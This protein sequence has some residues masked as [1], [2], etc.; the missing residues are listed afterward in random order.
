MYCLY[1][2]LFLAIFGP[3]LTFPVSASFFSFY[4]FAS[5]SII[6]PSMCL[7]LS[8]ICLFKL[9]TLFNWF[10]RSFSRFLSCA[11]KNWAR[12]FLFLLLGTIF[13]YLTFFIFFS[14]NGFFF[15]SKSM[16]SSLRFSMSS[17][18]GLYECPVEG[19]I[20]A[21]TFNSVLFLGFSMGSFHTSAQASYN[22]SC[23]L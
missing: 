21:G 22:K 16:T 14:F 1:W 10:L 23:L 7:F 5:F 4:F 6:F 17:G 9:L 3:S 15:P 8:S 18:L 13:I 2:Y 20:T 12:T 11:A 19:F